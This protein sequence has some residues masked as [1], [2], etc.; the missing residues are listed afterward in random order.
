VNICWVSEG[1]F[2]PSRLLTAQTGQNCWYCVR[3]EQMHQH[4]LPILH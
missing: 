2:G 4:N 1:S 3:G